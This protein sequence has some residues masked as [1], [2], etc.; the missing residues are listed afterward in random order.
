MSEMKNKLDNINSSLGTLIIR[1]CINLLKDYLDYIITTIC[2][3][4]ML[5]EAVLLS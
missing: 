4:K 3:S 1:H 5:G 2:I